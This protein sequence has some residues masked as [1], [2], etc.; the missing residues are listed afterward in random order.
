MNK[1]QNQSDLE[2]HQET[3]RDT[4]RSRDFVK[5]THRGGDQRQRPEAKET[6]SNERSGGKHAAGTSTD[7]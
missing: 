4:Q 2:T 6:H 3:Q 7:A 5:N 1:D